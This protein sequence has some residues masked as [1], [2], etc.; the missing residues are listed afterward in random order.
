ML[1][2]NDSVRATA[3]FVSEQS[4]NRTIYIHCETCNAE[5]TLLAT[6][7]PIRLR[8]AINVFRCFACNHVTSYEIQP[9]SSE[10]A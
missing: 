6:L 7:P 1:V 3:T 5:M 4:A 2:D 8:A 10:A 9:D